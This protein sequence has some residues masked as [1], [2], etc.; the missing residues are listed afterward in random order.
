[1]EGFK[2]YAFKNDIYL[3]GLSGRNFFDLQANRFSVQD[4]TANAAATLDSKQPWV[5]PI[6]DY[7]RTAPDP[8][9]GG[10]LNYN[11]NAQGILRYGRD[12]ALSAIR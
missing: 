8:V 10:E 1:M 5:L 12:F 2:D 7:S 11:I 4:S 3:T 6:F 9:L